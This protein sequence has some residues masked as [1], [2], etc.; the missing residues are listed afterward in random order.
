MNR[1]FLDTN[2]LLDALVTK[3]KRPEA[4]EAMMLLREAELGKVELL[5]SSMSLG[6]VL[7]V[8]QTGSAKRKGKDLDLLKTVM[9]SVLNIVQLVHVRRKH[10][11]QCFN[12]RFIDLED[13]C[14]YFA[15]SDG[16]ILTAIVSRDKDIKG[17][18]DI[19]VISAGEAL[20]HL[21]G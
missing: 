17:H 12:S 6:A 21:G 13:G 7:Y 3:E 15:A 20:K 19:P 8:L 2:I 18:V 10:I 5:L 11:E 4:N 14:Q 1:Y 9:R 16:R